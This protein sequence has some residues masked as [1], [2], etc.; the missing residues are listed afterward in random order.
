MVRIAFGISQNMLNLYKQKMCRHF[1]A[2]K[3]D[4]GRFGGMEGAYTVIFHKKKFPFIV[5]Q[6]IN[7]LDIFNDIVDNRTYLKRI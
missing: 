5:N 4:D 2:P 6:T 1:Y 3:N 7:F